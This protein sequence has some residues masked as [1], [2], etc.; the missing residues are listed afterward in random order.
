MEG[1]LEKK[2]VI[3]K[4]NDLMNKKE[5]ENNNLIESQE[6]KNIE[7]KKI[8][9]NKL[10]DYFK[11]IENE[12]K[13]INVRDFTFALRRLISR[14]LAGARQD[15]DIKSDLELH[16]Q[17]VKNEFWSKEIADNDEKDN[18]LAAICIK[19][20]KIG[21]AFDLYNLLDGDVILSKE[22]DKNKKKEKEK[23]KEENIK[24]KKDD[25]SEFKI[26]KKKG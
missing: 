25:I 2:E 26:N 22:I 17:I 7:N 13:I 19:D 16:L 8:G 4:L 11:K 21:N 1:M 3:D 5:K 14:Y 20:I 10:N 23:E 9:I 15:I 12:K 24:D 6:N 18:E